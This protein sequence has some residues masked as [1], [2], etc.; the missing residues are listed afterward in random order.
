[1]MDTNLKLPDGRSALE[2][3]LERIDQVLSDRIEPA[4][5]GYSE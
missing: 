2:Q 4:V 3:T 1:M 5:Q